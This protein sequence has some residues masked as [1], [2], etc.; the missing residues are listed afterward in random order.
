MKKSCEEDLKR[1][2]AAWDDPKTH[3]L[4]IIAWGGVGKTSLVVEWMARKAADG[5]PG[6]ERVFE[7]TFYSQGTH[8]QGTASAGLFIAEAP[9]FFGDPDPTQG[10]S[11][12]RGER[13]ARLVAD[14]ITSTI[15]ASDSEELAA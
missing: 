12:D 5:W 1:L 14:T 11:W 3:I 6:F 10:S 4:I 13:L 2:D 8:E 7:W 9:K 15:L